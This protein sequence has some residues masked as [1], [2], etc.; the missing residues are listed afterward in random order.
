MLARPAYKNFQVQ[1]KGRPMGGLA[2]ITPKNIRKHTTI[3]KSLSWRIQPVVIK[4][5]NKSNLIINSYFPTD[6]RTLGGQNIELENVLAEISNVIHS[7][8]FNCLY[9]IG[10]INCNFIRNSSHV[11]T[12]RDFMNKTNLY[13]VWREFP[14]DFTHSY[15][16]EDGICHVNTIDHFL[17]LESSKDNILDAGVLHMV[18]NQ[19]DHEPIYMVVKCASDKLQSEEKNSENIQM[20]KP[21]WNQASSDQKLEFNDFVFRKLSAMEIPSELTDCRN[22]HCEN[23]EHK[24]K[25]DGFVEEVL[26]N[27]SDS[28]FETLPLSKPRGRGKNNQRKKTAGWIEYVEPYQDN[29][30][31]WHSVWISAGRPINTELHKIMKRTRNRFHYQVRKCRRVESYIKNQ[32]IVENC[33]EGD[34]DL[35]NEI[36]KQRANTNEDDVTIDGAAGDDIPGKFAE[37]YANLYNSS[38]DDEKVLNIKN[39]INNNIGQ[40]DLNEVDK[41]NSLT[42]KEAIEK[43]KSNKTDPIHDFSSDFLKHS[44]DILFE[45]LAVIIKAFVTHGHVTSS[46]LV[47]TLVPIVKDKLADLCSSKNYRSIAISSLILK[48]LDWI[49]LLNYGHLLKTNDFQFGFQKCSNT[50]L[51][52]WVV[53]ETI[54]QYLRKGSIVYGCLLDCS[55]AF[56]TVEH[57]KLFEKLLDAKIPAIIVRLLITIYRNQTAKVRW[58]EGFSEEFLIRNGVRQGAVIS[59]IFFSF[60]MDNLFDLLQSNRSGCIISNYYAGCYGYADDLL[61]L[62]PSRS[63]LQEMLSIAEKY[64]EEHSISFSTDPEPRKSKTKGIIFTK[65]A[66]QFTPAPLILNGNPLPW[67]S[68]SKYLGNTITSIPDGWSKDAN[69]KRACY[70][71]RKTLK[72]CKSSL[73]PILRLNVD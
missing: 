29:A 62:C 35:F 36:K 69:Q 18:Q 10:D 11:E 5:G 49:I 9:L 22:V 54:D 70:I 38:S 41:I 4:V 25:I 67:I 34:M 31:F 57:S 32:K 65:K 51:C 46:L 52:S 30:K 7:T 63:G 45:Y 53:Y 1:D 8:S 58:K 73:K 27:I 6:P 72:F 64:V 13:S 3:L 50:S 20:P 17:T 37:V 33:L 39:S 16:K 28:G 66:L 23:P 21:K 59:P 43:I 44:P 24:M 48:L 26:K 61:F 12:V 15:Q 68:E 47:A 14:I 40:S 60:Y 56:D 42:I 71:E 55:K 2:M 19:S